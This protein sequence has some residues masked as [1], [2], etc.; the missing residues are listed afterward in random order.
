VKKVQESKENKQNGGRNWIDDDNID[1]MAAWQPT[2]F[3]A[4][5]AHKNEND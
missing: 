2:E 5:V 3:R 1:E 4:V